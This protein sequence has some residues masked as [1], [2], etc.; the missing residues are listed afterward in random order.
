MTI[1]RQIAAATAFV[2]WAWLSAGGC[3]SSD[4]RA[5]GSSGQPTAGGSTGGTRSDPTI[6]TPDPTNVAG[7]MG[8][9]L[10]PLCGG[11]SLRGRSCL[12]DDV[13]AC[14][15]YDPP[16][17]SSGA[18]GAATSEL[19]SSG[20]GGAEGTAGANAGGNLPSGGAG[21]AAG[22]NDGGTGGDGHNKPVPPA[23]YSCQVARK[24]DQLTRICVRA[25]AGK[26][27]GLCRSATDCAPG[28]A[29]VKEGNE[30]N[31]GVCRPYC[32]SKD[33]ICGAQSYCG[34]RSLFDAARTDAPRVPVCVPAHG[35][36]LDEPFPCPSG[37]CQ[38]KG[39]TA[40]LVVRDDGT[41]ACV[42]PGNGKDGEA[43]PC[44]WNQVC[45]SVTKTCVRICRT[46]RSQKD[47]GEQKC[48][49][50][51]ELPKNYGVCVGPLR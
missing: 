42:T 50:S 36:S 1:T 25:G 18:A 29:C 9:G 16:R 5:T 10:S 40:C 39:E 46:D 30:D 43:C 8:E 7:A 47:C 13:G 27:T 3:A 34:S 11:S 15:D 45:S 19:G 35:C 6:I 12:P 33:T 24:D 44:A 21:G 14:I 37:D 22:A 31:G 17:G 23:T 51:A 28:L 49:A 2:G 20:A 38:C 32:C 26:A 4:D 41:T 48:Q